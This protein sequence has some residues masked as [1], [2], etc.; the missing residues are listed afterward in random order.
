MKHASCPSCEKELDARHTQMAN[1][2]ATIV[3]TGCGSWM[4]IDAKNT[5]NL[6]LAALFIGTL[7]V[8]W[9]IPV[10]LILLPV[11]LV[12]SSGGSDRI[13]VTAVDKRPANLWTINRETGEM[14]QL[15]KLADAQA[16]SA[17][18][19]KKPDTVSKKFSEMRPFEAKRM[20]QGGTPKRKYSS[21]KPK[22]DSDAAFVS[23]DFAASRPHELPH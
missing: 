16:E 5:G 17:D 12:L 21:K 18:A 13:V 6:T 4:R 23:G 14:E 11:Y 22:A 8:A 10:V 1:L 19:G 20:A 9:F 2:P 7:A 3:C 15:S